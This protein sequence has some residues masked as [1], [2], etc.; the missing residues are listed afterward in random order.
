MN[1]YDWCGTLLNRRRRTTKYLN[2]NILRMYDAAT[3]YRVLHAHIQHLSSCLIKGQA[4][5]HVWLVWHT[6]E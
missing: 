6:T 2:L 5:E 1:V 4:D 3:V